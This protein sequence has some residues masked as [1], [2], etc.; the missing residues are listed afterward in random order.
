[1]CILSCLSLTSGQAR[2]LNIHG[3]VLKHFISPTLRATVR[4]GGEDAD[5]R[6]CFMTAI[7]PTSQPALGVYSPPNKSAIDTATPKKAV[8]Y[9]FCS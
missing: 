6:H 8:P 4:T 2:A 9:N 7:S 5:L 1:M 3:Y